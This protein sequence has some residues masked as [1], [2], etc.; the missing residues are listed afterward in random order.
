MTGKFHP[1]FFNSAMTALWPAV[2]LLNLSSDVHANPGPLPNKSS[3]HFAT[4]TGTLIR[5]VKIFFFGFL[6]W[7]LTIPYLNTTSYHCVKPVLVAL[8]LFLK[9]H[10]PGYLYYPPNNPY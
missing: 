10:S 8:L 6:F 3:Y 2:L 5:S 7:R 9:M 1:W 4:G